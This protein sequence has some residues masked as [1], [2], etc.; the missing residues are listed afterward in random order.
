MAT[1]TCAAYREFGGIWPNESGFVHLV[2][3]FANDG[4]SISPTAYYL[5]RANKECILLDATV[6][7]ETAVD[8]AGDA[9]VVKIG[10]TGV[11]DSILSKSWGHQSCLTADARFQCPGAQGQVMAADDYV[12]AVLSVEA[13]TAGK[14]H[15]YLR[16]ANA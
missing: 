1:V 11:A 15:V 16:Y 3:D 14:I 7:V 10:T 6:L 5:G 2:Y 4:G 13:L 9:A 8:S 12:I